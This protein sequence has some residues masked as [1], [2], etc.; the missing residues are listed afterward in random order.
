MLPRLIEQ[1]LG[2]DTPLRPRV[3]L[4]PFRRGVRRGRRRNGGWRFPEAGDRRDSA[5]GPAAAGASSWGSSRNGSP[6]KDT[7]S[8]LAARP[9]SGI[10]SSS[11]SS[12][13][14][15]RVP[16]STASSGTSSMVSMASAPRWPRWP[17]CPRAFRSS[18]GPCELC[19]DL[20][21]AAPDR[22]RPGARRPLLQLS[23][24]SWARRAAGPAR[25]LSDVLL[26]AV[27]VEQPQAEPMRARDISGRSLQALTALAPRPYL[28]AHPLRSAPRRGRDPRLH[29]PAPDGGA[30]AGGSSTSSSST[31]SAGFLRRR[32]RRRRRRKGSRSFP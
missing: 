4:F 15:V 28:S 14:G 26:V 23:R 3:R 11:T 18:P 17:R 7:S 1:A 16:V 5:L 22:G 2:V 13:A 32:P 20:L 29:E 27:K 10:V 6:P 31:T 25:P 19:H 30:G 21:I 12:S 9:A 8:I 24:F